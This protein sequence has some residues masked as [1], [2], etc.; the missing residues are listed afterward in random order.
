MSAVRKLEVNGWDLVVGTDDVPR[1]RDIDLGARLG[2]AR[3]RDFRKLVARLLRDGIVNDIQCRATVARYK[4][5]NL[6]GFQ[7]VVEYHLDERAALM[8]IVKSETAKAVEITGQVIDVYLA[9]RTASRAVAAEQR[10]TIHRVHGLLRRKYRVASAY[11]L[12]MSVW[13]S[14]KGYLEGLASPR[15]GA[16]SPVLQLVRRPRQLAL[17][18]VSGS[19]GLV[20]STGPQV[21]R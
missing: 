7:D 10:F 16:P 18:G 14:A 19:S 11:A 12:S 20:C 4:V 21:S 1:V 17:P 2:F 15:F 3:P 8:A 9:V 6:G 13:P 5:G